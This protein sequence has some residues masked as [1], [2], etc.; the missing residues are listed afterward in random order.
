MFIERR[1]ALVT[2]L[3]EYLRK[4]FPGIM[5]VQLNPGAP[6]P[7]YPFVAFEPI[8]PLTPG[9]VVVTEQARSYGGTIVESRYTQDRMTFSWSIYDDDIDRAYRIATRAMQWFRH[10]GHE[11]MKAKGMIL[12]ECTGIQNRDVYNVDSWERR[13]GFDTI[14]RA[15]NKADIQT[16]NIEHI[17][18]RRTY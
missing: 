14:I 6:R 12:V 5:L 13:L 3:R 15:I 2:G 7:D 10:D 4:V 1:N 18:M 11:Q 8:V 16:N 9:S 17:S